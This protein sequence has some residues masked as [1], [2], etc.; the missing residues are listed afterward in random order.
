MALVFS[1]KIWRSDAAGLSVDWNWDGGVILLSTPT[2]QLARE[3]FHGMKQA[4]SYYKRPGAV[5]LY[6]NDETRNIRLDFY[7]Y[8][9]EPD[10]CMVCGGPGFFTSEN[11]S[12]K[13]LCEECG[14]TGKRKK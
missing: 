13:T 7:E 8:V 6:M 3:V 2:E 5:E 12:L 9:V 4:I 14:G 11:G 10:H 1:V